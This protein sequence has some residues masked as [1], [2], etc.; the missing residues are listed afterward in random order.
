MQEQYHVISAK[1]QGWANEG[2]DF[3]FPVSEYTKDQAISE[4]VPVEKITEKN[5]HEFPYTAYEYN[6]DTFYEFIYRGVVDESDL[7]YY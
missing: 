7:N 1:Y 6:G 2:E 5:G 3:Y 4:F